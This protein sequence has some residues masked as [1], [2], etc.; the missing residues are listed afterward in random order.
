MLYTDHFI[1]RAVALLLAQVVG[2]PHT[3]F[4]FSGVPFFSALLSLL[5]GGG[6]GGVPCCIGGSSLVRA[7]VDFHGQT[8]VR[9]ACCLL[10][11]HLLL[12]PDSH[13]QRWDAAKEESF[14][15][16]PFAL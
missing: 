8:A 16:F 12:H 14:L 6:G 2:V 10:Q 7:V 11:T 9:T 1:S 3:F 15:R 13:P 5:T 4:V